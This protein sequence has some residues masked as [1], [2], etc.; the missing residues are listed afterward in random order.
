MDRDLVVERGRAA[1]LQPAG[2]GP[3]INQAQV[4]AF[5]KP[6]VTR[7]NE[8]MEKA[9]EVTSPE[10]LNFMLDQFKE[11]V[12]KHGSFSKSVSIPLGLLFCHF[13]LLQSQ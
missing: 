8:I 5:E 9:A 3:V 6:Q 10:K 1:T 4:N 11:I 12:A 7:A 13:L 2:L